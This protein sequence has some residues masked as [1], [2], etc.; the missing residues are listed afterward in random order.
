MR[1][2]IADDHAIVRRG[3]AEILM[4][5]WPSAEIEQVGDA[6]LLLQRSLEDSWDLVISDLMMPGRSVLETLQQ[7]RQY[8]PHLPVLIL[9][10]F[11][12]EQYAT[13]VFKAGASGYINKD[14]APT[15]LVKAVQRILQGRKYITP[16]VAEKLASDLTVD[17]ERPPHELLSDREFHVMKLLAVGK[18]ITEIAAQ[19]SLSPTTISTYRSRIMEKMKMKANAELARYALENS[20]I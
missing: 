9:S 11:P 6:D 5:T 17:K 7:I 8:Q 12:E 1:I 15:E 4:E 20:L 19:M 2:L 10:I 13:R 18:S 3:L 16:A 14:A